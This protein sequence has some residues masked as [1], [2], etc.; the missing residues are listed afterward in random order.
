MTKA[1]IL[2][3]LLLAGSGFA[4]YGYLNPDAVRFRKTQRI[5]HTLEQEVKS[6]NS[7]GIHSALSDLLAPEASIRIELEQPSAQGQTPAAAEVQSFARAEFL[8]FVDNL[9]YSTHDTSLVIRLLSMQRSPDAK[10]AEI[11]LSAN[12]SAAGL[13]GSLGEANL[14]FAGESQ[15]EGTLTLES[16]PANITRLSCTT[17]VYY[18]QAGH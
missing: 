1:I 18:R 7:A 11:T 15:C 17:T 6:G 4:A 12:E 3:L 10:T 16:E 14:R 8:T 2:I 9:V 13:P 5:F